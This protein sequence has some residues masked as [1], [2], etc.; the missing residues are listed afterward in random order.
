[1]PEQNAIAT[2]IGAAYNIA[3]VFPFLYMFINHHV[4]VSDRWLVTVFTIMGVAVCV[5]VGLY[6]HLTVVIAGASYSVVIAT[7]S[8]V[9]GSSNHDDLCNLSF[10][11]SHRPV[12]AIG[13]V[14]GV[15]LFAY[16]ANYKPFCTTGER[17]L[18]VLG[19]LCA[20]EH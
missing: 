12:G 15:T 17:L 4:P 1:M 6:W 19:E 5:I 9:S 13:C 10:A 14:L 7:M 3:N 8:F 18:F 11:E 2:S 16:A 20:N